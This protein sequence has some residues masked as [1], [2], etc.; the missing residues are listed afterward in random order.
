MVHATPSSIQYLCT[1]I[2]EW[3]TTDN[4]HVQLRSKRFVRMQSAAYTLRYLIELFWI[5]FNENKSFE[6]AFSYECLHRNLSEL[7]L[8]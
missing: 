6:N 4:L 1:M 5:K 2:T 8:F 7:L 3:K